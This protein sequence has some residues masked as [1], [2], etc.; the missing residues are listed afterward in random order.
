M[1]VVVVVM[2]A[3][4]EGQGHRARSSDHSEAPLTPPATTPT[5]GGAVVSSVVPLPLQFL[6]AYH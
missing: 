6:L 4:G 5:T 1:M 3:G 2:G